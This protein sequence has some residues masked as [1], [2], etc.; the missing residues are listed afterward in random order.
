MRTAPATHGPIPTPMYRSVPGPSTLGWT[1]AESNCWRTGVSVHTATSSKR[2]NTYS[3]TR[4][5]PIN[6]EGESMAKRRRGTR[7]R[8][9]REAH[10]GQLGRKCFVCGGTIDFSLRDPDLMCATV[11]HIVPRYLGGGSSRGNTAVSHKACNNARHAQDDRGSA[12]VRTVWRRWAEYT[13][14]AAY[15]PIPFG[16]IRKAAE[17]EITE[18]PLF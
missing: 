18:E 5:R 3:P 12:Y 14:V 2:P 17:Y 10:L 16:R 7:V 13:Q 1:A 15:I 6:R 8:R 9:A 4:P 11:E